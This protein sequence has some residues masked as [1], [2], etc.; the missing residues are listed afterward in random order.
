M[1]LSK[2]LLF[3]LATAVSLSAAASA[4]T[5]TGTVTGPD[6]KPF[7]GAFVVAENTQTKMTVNVLS[8]V[9]GRYHIGKLPAASYAIKISAIGYGSDPKNDVTLSDEQKASFDFTLK[10]VPVR[11]SE[12]TTYQGRKLLPKTEKHDLSHRDELFSTCFQS[13]HSFQKRMATAERD[14]AGWREKVMYMRETIMHGSGPPMSN[15]KVEDIVSWLTLAFGPESPKTKSPEDMPDYRA[16]VRSF[17]P[18]A[19]NIAYVEYNFTA[20]KGMGPWS[21]V[22]DK[23]GMMWIPYYGRGNEVVR[24]NPKTAELTRFPLPYPRTAGI[25]S[26]IPAPDGTVWFS[27]ASLGRIGHL[28]PTTKEIKEY[29]NPALA[30]GRRTGA[31]TIRVDDLGR[32]WASGGPVITMLTPE[33]G[34]FKHFDLGRTYANVVGPNGDQWF[35]SFVLDGPIAKVSKDGVLSKYQPPTKGKP[36]RLVIDADNNVW[37]SERQGNKIGRFDTKTETFK[38]F[39][40]PGPEASPYA[41]GIDRAGMIWYSSHEQDTLNRLDPKSG[42]VTEYP[43][44]QSEI[45]MREFFLDSQGRMWY[46]SSVNNKIGY[47]YFNDAP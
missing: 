10:K 35:T 46:A 15:E 28:N 8:N 27:E 38:E 41:I 21:A 47:F 7:M 43:Y 14:E 2:S 13:C 37:F 4:A 24:L 6:G 20:P 3:S 40:L 12:L 11:W 29:H 19:M 1:S 22:E 16:L 39:P 9:Q 30:D 32:V 31:H 45:S 23:D 25:H 36:Q 17:S 34:A 26:A 18:A 33:T 44:P 5:V 42:E